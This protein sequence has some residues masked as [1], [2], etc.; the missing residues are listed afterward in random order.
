MEIITSHPEFPKLFKGSS[1]ILFSIQSFEGRKDNRDERLNLREYQYQEI[2]TFERSF[3]F[4]VF[5]F[6]WN[7]MGYNFFVKKK[8]KKGK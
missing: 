3:S 5:F 2:N 1:S 4:F 6:I 8:K 7:A